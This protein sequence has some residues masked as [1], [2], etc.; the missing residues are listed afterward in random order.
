[1]QADFSELRD[2]VAHAVEELRRE[3]IGQRE[4]LTRC[5]GAGGDEEFRRLHLG[6]ET[7]WKRRLNEVGAVREATMAGVEVAQDHLLQVGALN[8]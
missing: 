6:A 1:M 4:A 8:I 3:A 2:G 5:S 7:Q